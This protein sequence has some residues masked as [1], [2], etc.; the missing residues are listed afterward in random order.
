VPT[1]TEAD[2]RPAKSNY[3][4]IGPVKPRSVTRMR[5][6]FGPERILGVKSQFVWRTQLQP[7]GCDEYRVKP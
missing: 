3:D 1:G 6:F 5:C 2:R 7:C 4:L